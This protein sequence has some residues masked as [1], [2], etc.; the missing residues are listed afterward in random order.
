MDNG[1]TYV[2]VDGVRPPDPVQVPSLWLNPRLNRMSTP[3]YTVYL[4][5]KDL[6]RAK[7][8]PTSQAM[9][10]TVIKNHRDIQE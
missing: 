5:S 4:T 1:Y 9:T 3:E 2:L 6:G 8:Y 7:Q 10:G